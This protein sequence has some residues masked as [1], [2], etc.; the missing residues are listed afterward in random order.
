[1]TLQTNSGLINPMVIDRLTPYAVN[2]L[3]RTAPSGNAAGGKTL[4]ITVAII[5]GVVLV[6]MVLGIGLGA[7]AAGILSDLSF[8]NVTNSTSTG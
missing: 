4:I 8:V 7:G 5:G 2:P 6:G 3:V 1:M